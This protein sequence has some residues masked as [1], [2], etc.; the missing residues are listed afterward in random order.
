M[1]QRRNVPCVLEVLRYNDP[2]K[3]VSVQFAA[4]THVGYMNKKFP[5]ANAAAAYYHAHNRHMP[6]IS[7]ASGIGSYTLYSAWDPATLL[8]YAIRRDHDVHATIAPFTEQ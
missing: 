7:L 8:A 3:D 2:A 4:Y 6:Q 5:S 1:E